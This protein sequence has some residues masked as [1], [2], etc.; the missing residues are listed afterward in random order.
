MKKL[1]FLSVVCAVA[2]ATSSFVFATDNPLLGRTIALDAGHGGGETGAIGYCGTV[3]AVE[4]DVNAAVR[5]A[6]EAKLI[7]AGANVFEVPQISSRKDRVAAAEAAGSDVL[8]SIHHNGSSN[9]TADYTQS[10]ITQKNDKELALPIQSAL[11]AALGI[12]NKGIKNDGYGMTVYGRLPGV[13]TEAYF[14]TDT[15]EACDFL[16]IKSIGSKTR[17]ETE[18]EAMYTGLVQYFSAR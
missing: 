18:A 5:S 8:I 7:A 1:T 12:P 6:L 16:G 17:I 9:L 2:V 4:A 13:L 3:A 14:I 10:F 15:D 11:V